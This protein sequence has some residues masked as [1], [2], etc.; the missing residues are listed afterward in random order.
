HPICSHLVFDVCTYVESELEQMASTERKIVIAAGFIL[1]TMMLFVAYSIFGLGIRLPSCV[2][3]VSPFEKGEI[4]K[5][6]EGFY[7]VHIV[8]RMWAFEPEEI[9]VPTG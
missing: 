1:L 4:I 2:T 6:A 8:A 3:T 9:Q 7:E 5:K